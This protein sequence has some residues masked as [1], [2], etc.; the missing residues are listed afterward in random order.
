VL[1]G[2]F[3]AQ[4]LFSMAIEADF[5][6]LGVLKNK[7][8]D[9][10]VTLVA[11]LAFFGSYRRVDNLLGELRLCF[12]VAIKALLLNTTGSTPSARAATEDI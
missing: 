11:G 4:L 1:I 8:S 7:G 6:L 2:F 10:T 9:K 12:R 5:F 3:Q